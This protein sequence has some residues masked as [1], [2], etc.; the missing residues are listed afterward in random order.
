MDGD[1]EDVITEALIEHAEADRKVSCPRCAQWSWHGPDAERKVIEHWERAHAQPP[2][3]EPPDAATV[4]AGL[5]AAFEH[6]RWWSADDEVKFE[7][8]TKAMKRVEA[9]QQ[10]LVQNVEQL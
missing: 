1:A 8:W 2:A 10:R 7:I 4:L 6:E 5:L 9:A 3:P